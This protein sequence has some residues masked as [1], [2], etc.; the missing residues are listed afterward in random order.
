MIQFFDS[1]SKSE[2][3]VNLLFNRYKNNDKVN[4]F[5][6]RFK[7]DIPLKLSRFYC[8]CDLDKKYIRYENEPYFIKTTPGFK[9]YPN[10][11]FLKDF[12]VPIGDTTIVKKSFNENFF[13]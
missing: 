8:Y 13:W 12:K 9:Y 5:I 10:T 2:L 1:K 6:K 7:D 11:L 3:Q 4:N